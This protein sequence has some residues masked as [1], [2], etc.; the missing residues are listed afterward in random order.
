MKLFFTLLPIAMAFPAFFT[1]YAYHLHMFQLNSYHYDVEWKWLMR[2]ADGF[3]LLFLPCGAGVVAV[4]FLTILLPAAAVYIYGG[5][6]TVVFAAIWLA[7]AYR[8]LKKKAKKPLVFTDRVKRLSVTAT[9]IFFIVTLAL[10]L[11]PGFIKNDF[12]FSG[13]WALIA[14]CVVIG[15]MP[16]YVMLANLINTPVEKSIRRKFTNE[17]KKLLAGNRDMKIIGVTG[18]YGKTSVKYFLTTLLSAR[19]NTLMTPENFNT[20]MGVVRT[21][22]E[23]LSPLHEVFVCEMGAKRV[24]EIKELCDLVHPQIGVITAVGPQHLD[25]FGS[26]DNVRKTKFELARALPK[27]GV[28]FLNADS[29]E[30]M[31]E[32]Y[33]GKK[34]LYS[35]EGRGDY[36]GELLRVSDEGTTFALRH[37]DEYA[38]FTMPLIGG[39]NVL[40]VVGAIAVAHEMGISYDELR[41]QVRKLQG[42]PHRLQLIDRGNLAIIDDAYN[43]NPAGAKAAVE[44][45]K[46]FDGYRIL[47]TPGMVE[48]GEKMYECNKE[49]GRQASSCCDYAVL[50]GRKQAEPIYEGLIDGGFP[51]EKIY[52]AENFTEAIG[53][54]YKLPTGGKKPFILL[55]NDL[56]DN[57]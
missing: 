44:T 33:E 35:T 54:A 31:K 9:V 38:E 57:F 5:L 51:K 42:V 20:P 28:V 47:V 56:P 45:L 39:H 50:V 18:S 30:V 34:I 25:T 27:D 1:V 26:Q 14:C 36:N 15:L 23:H 19:Y 4:V 49:F 24:G 52:I 41:P 3:A 29:E 6:L 43:S 2:N 53:H 17:A 12:V 32:P 40:N 22:R 7:F 55:E 48:L 10:L 37:G 21:V 16:L 13:A 8:K 46:G 11:I